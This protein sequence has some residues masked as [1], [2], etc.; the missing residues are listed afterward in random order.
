[1]TR[2]CCSTCIKYHHDVI[3]LV[4]KILLAINC[5]TSHILQHPIPNN[6]N[7]D[8]SVSNFNPINQSAKNSNLSR[9]K[10]ICC[11][12]FNKMSSKK[13]V[14]NHWGQIASYLFSKYL[15]SFS[16]NKLTSEKSYASRASWWLCTS[17]YS[18]LIK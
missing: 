17:A 11:I 2:H 1:M 16:K 13:I 8:F 18:K 12:L 15:C 4:K 6:I 10:E 7:F 5:T 14:Q 9:N 3:I